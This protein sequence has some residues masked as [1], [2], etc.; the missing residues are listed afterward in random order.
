MDNRY[1]GTVVQ[2]L[3]EYTVAV[4]IGQQ[5]NISLDMEFL[6]VGIG[7]EIIDP[8]TKKSLGNLEKV[9]GKVKVIHVQEQLS[10]LKSI[11]YIKKP[12]TKEVVR[13]IAKPHRSSISGLFGDS[14]TITESIK[15]EPPTLKKI[16]SVEIGD[17]IIFIK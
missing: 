6:I 1:K 5:N 8:D 16:D 3:D 7:D 2:V 13:K 15:S 9:R 17:K 10:T 12:E 4:N 14:E 11:E